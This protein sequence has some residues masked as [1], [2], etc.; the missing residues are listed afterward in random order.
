MAE[1]L[2]S[3]LQQAG[4][5]ETTDT[6]GGDSYNGNTGWRGGSNAHLERMLG[7]K[8]HWCVCASHTNEL[9]LRHLIE[10]VDGKTNSKDGFIGPIG[11]LLGK[12]MEM[13]INPDFEALPG[14]EDLYPL[15]E[16]VVKNMCTDACVSYKY[17]CAIKECHLPPELANLKPGPIVHS[18]WLTNGE[19][20]LFLWTRHHGLVGNEAKNLKVLV[21]FCVE[22]YFKMYFDIKV[23]H[24][25]I[26]GPYH[27][28]MQL[29]ILQTQPN[30]FNSKCVLY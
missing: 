16:E 28:L 13:E 21:K 30:S 25:L 5:T 9:P 24:H 1:G 7:H 20:L 4:A 27:I 26:H 10:K 29:R 19:A 22:S 11:K 18:R 14:G 6:L 3:I 23:K 2:Y 8:C 15:S 12:V 17:I